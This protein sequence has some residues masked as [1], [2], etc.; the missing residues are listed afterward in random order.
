M[1]KSVRK[2]RAAE[3]GPGVPKI[4]FPLNEDGNDSRSYEKDYQ[5]SPKTGVGFHLPNVEAL[6][7]LRRFLYRELDDWATRRKL[8]VYNWDRRHSVLIVL[9]LLFAKRFPR[10]L[11]LPQ[12][13]T[14]VRLQSAL[15]MC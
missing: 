1:E 14:P 3:D 2:L 6:S 9:A 8:L 5:F 4:F 7:G 12:R 10:F 13:Q 15:N 11:E